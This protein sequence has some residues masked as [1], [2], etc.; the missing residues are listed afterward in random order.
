MAEDQKPDTDTNAN[1]PGQQPTSVPQDASLPM[2]PKDE[3]PVN[4]KPEA[5]TQKDNAT[6]VNKEPQI[7]IINEQ[8]DGWTC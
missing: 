2:P 4:K 6:E 8:K 1:T 5:T 3:E 7:V